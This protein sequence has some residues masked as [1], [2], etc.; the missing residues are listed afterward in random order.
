[1]HENEVQ[2]SSQTSQRLLS[3]FNLVLQVGSW[4]LQ[5]G[6][7]SGLD[8]AYV[9]GDLVKCGVQVACLQ[10]THCPEGCLVK[11]EGVGKVFC[12]ADSVDT[13]EAYPYGLGFFLSKDLEAYY[14]DHRY[15]S[16]RCNTRVAM[17]QW[18][19]QKVTQFEYD[20]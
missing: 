19:H 18:L 14:L 4:N 7:K 2:S 10:E 8:F 11:G 1:M 3:L 5:G 16:N 12:L 15:I 20:L 9:F 6:L 13:P 17:F